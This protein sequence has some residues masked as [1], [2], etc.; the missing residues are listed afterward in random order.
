VNRRAFVT[1]AGAAIASVA[2]R[3]RAQQRL[4]LRV[5]LG[6][7]DA[8]TLPGGGFVFA[9]RAYRGSFVRA[10]DGSIVNLV[11]LD[12]YLCSVV[13]REMSASWP[14]AALQAQALCTRT[15][16]LRRVDRTKPYDIGSSES[17][18]VYSGRDVESAAGCAAVAATSGSVLVFAGGYADI[19][20]SSCCGGRTE[21]GADAWGGRQLPYLSSIACPYC[22]QSP[23]YRW[24]RDIPVGDLAD[25]VTGGVDAESEQVVDVRLGTRDASG[26]AR[27]VSLLT[28]RGTIEIPAERF[29]LSVGSHDLPSLMIFRAALN[30]GIAHFEGGGSGHGVGMCQWG[31]RGL[32]STG[33]TLAN[34]A[35]F[36]FPGTRIDTWTNVSSPPSN[37]N[38]RRS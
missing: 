33:G 2:V 20:Y 12:D 22:A 13:S 9:G 11:A 27:S 24:V 19:A 35:S 4:E 5:L 29:R 17:A 6:S 37:T 15:Y 25:D 23:E 18:Q 14:A 8:E 1:A 26:R 31:A 36:Y 30:A 32:A 7:G 10:A 38:F 3:A 28:Q 16:V 34:I 21:S